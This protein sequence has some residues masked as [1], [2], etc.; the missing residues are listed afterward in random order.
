MADNGGEG[1]A[2]YTGQIT[3]SGSA[4]DLRLQD[5]CHR[6]KQVPGVG[7]QISGGCIELIKLKHK[8]EIANSNAI[9]KIVWLHVCTAKSTSSGYAPNVIH[10]KQRQFILKQVEAY[11]K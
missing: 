9:R 5:H 8:T 10:N 11:I 6:S 3:G 1:D 4:G 7:G 2:Y